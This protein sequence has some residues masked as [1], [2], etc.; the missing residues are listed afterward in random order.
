[1]YIHTYYVTSA[2]GAIVVAQK[3]PA[4]VQ[5]LGGRGPQADVRPI[6]LLTLPLLILLDSNFRGNPLW[7]WEFNPLKLR[8]CLSQTP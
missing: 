2:P 1:M 7:A 5:H 8:L 6:S 4:L 3:T